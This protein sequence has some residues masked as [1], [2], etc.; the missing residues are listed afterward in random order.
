[1][2]TEKDAVKLRSPEF[3]T[4][5]ADIPIFYQPMRIEFFES[6]KSDFNSQ[7]INYVA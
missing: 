5:L 3:A 1:M 6:S 4:I 7:I 2:T